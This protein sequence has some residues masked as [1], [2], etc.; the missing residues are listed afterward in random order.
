M[1]TVE[2][3][4]G[5]L[6]PNPSNRTVRDIG[7]LTESI[8]NKGILEPLIVAPALDVPLSDDLPRQYALIAGH[9]RL[10]AAAA[11]GLDLVECKIREDLDTK[12]LQLE[13]ALEENIHRSDLTPIEEAQ[14]Y[15]ELLEFPGYTIAKL[16][17]A[18]GRAQTT[19]KSRLALMKLGEPMREQIHEGQIS[20]TDAQV[21]ADYA[22]K[23]AA[24]KELADTVGT[25]NF[26]YTVERL[27]H[28]DEVE[29][30][31]AKTGKALA[32]DNV[33]V[34]DPVDRWNTDIATHLIELG[35]DPANHIECAGH[36]AFVQRA[37][38]KAVYVCTQAKVHARPKPATQR[39]RMAKTD[40]A[41][42]QRQAEA[43][44]LFEQLRVA[45]RLRRRH[46]GEVAARATDELPLSL[47]RTVLV[48]LI[49]DCPQN[50][51]EDIWA[52]FAPVAGAAITDVRGISSDE[53]AELIS[54]LSLQQL[55]MLCGLFSN[56][57]EENSLEEDAGAF[58][59]VTAPDAAWRDLVGGPFAYEWSE[60][61]LRWIGG[62]ATALPDNDE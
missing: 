7:E 13:A 9:R 55:A 26:K 5:Q 41:L 39:E 12:Q 29:K 16:S 27:R 45:A 14:A 8:R 33:T 47:L 40:P 4:I 42:A 35:I 6:I 51:F 38:G 17:K 59:A 18:T 19:V 24:L 30:T 1:S 44:R 20:I 50:F 25:G 15:Q 52:G 11:A 10:A 54:D 43:D 34:I 22:S 3:L 57:W 36:A 62:D 32:A 56:T 37:T 58:A 21:F 46:L 60:P 49:D 28:R 48:E 31:A 23:P 2:I 53:I 61:E